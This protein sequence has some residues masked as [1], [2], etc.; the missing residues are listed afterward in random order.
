MRGIAMSVTSD[1]FEITPYMAAVGLSISRRVREVV[2]SS[3][4]H[5]G[6]HTII[7]RGARRSC[8]EVVSSGDV[9]LAIGRVTALALAEVP[10]P[11]VAIDEN[12]T[13]GQRGRHRNKKQREG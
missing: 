8:I 13:N 2:S 10:V 9:E 11:R 4:T 7:A 3:V 12:R 1:L 6:R 5:L